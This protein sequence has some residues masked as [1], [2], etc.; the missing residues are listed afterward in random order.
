MDLVESTPKN[1]FTCFFPNS[2]TI[3]TSASNTGKTSLI[4]NLIQNRE[5]FFTR[6]FNELVVVLCNPLVDGRIYQNLESESLRVTVVYLE[7][8]IVEEF[9]SENCV[10]IFDDVAEL[11]EE[12]KSIIRVDSHHSNYNSCLLVVQSVLADDDLKAL[13]TLVHRVVI[14]FTGYGASKLAKY[15]QTYFIKFPRGF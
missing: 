14:F 10:V 3:L 13:L 2:I 5:T 7:E 4:L 11:T 1:F 9:L 12:I 8:F 15:I 6:E